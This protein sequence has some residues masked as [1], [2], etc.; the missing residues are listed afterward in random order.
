MSKMNH[1]CAFSESCDWLSSVSWLNGIAVM[2]IW[3]SL[4]LR[5][6]TMGLLRIS[7]F[8]LYCPWT[9][10]S[11]PI[12]EACFFHWV[13]KKGRIFLSIG[14]TYIYP[15]VNSLIGYM[16]RSAREENREDKKQIILERKIL[17][18]LDRIA[19]EV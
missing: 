4:K 6:M 10:Q 12:K 11:F 18:L 3:G 2:R 8:I 5:E 14:N 19:C 9:N 13:A 1:C 7:G 16:I 17:W 15:T